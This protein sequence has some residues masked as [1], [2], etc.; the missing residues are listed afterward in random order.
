MSGTDVAFYFTGDRGGLVFDKKTTVQSDG[1]DH[2]PMAGLLM[3]EERLV[4]QPVDPTGAVS[5]DLLDPI[6]RHHIRLRRPSLC[7]P[8]VSSA[9]T[10]E[11]CWAL[12]ICPPAAS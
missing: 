2:R 11:P 8:I 9:T 3:M 10:R 12:S 6:T 1:T 4:G 7:G 5:I